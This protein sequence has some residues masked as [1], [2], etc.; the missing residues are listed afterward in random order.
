MMMRWLR[1]SSSCSI[2]LQLIDAPPQHP[3]HHP[4]QQQ[5]EEHAQETLSHEEYPPFEFPTEE[6]HFPSDLRLRSSIDMSAPSPSGAYDIEM[7]AY[8]SYASEF[9]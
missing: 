8:D 6:T 2:L 1:P 4:Q 5:A 9:V 3:A 7:S